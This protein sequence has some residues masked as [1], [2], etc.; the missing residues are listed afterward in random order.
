MENPLDEDAEPVVPHSDDI[1][2]RLV[3]LL[4]AGDVPERGVFVDV[5]VLSDIAEKARAKESVGDCVD[6]AMDVL[7]VANR[8]IVVKALVVFLALA[9]SHTY[10][11][12]KV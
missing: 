11:K 1:D 2:G 9:R 10:H 5:R 7:G 3:L 8:R 12:F 4:S 6:C